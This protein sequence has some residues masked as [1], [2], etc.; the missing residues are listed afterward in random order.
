[1]SGGHGDK[2][3]PGNRP[4]SPPIRGEI[5]ELQTLLGIG[6]DHSAQAMLLVDENVQT[7]CAN[8]SAGLLFGS[9]PSALVGHRNADFAAVEWTAD[10]DRQTV[11]FRLGDLDHLER[12]TEVVTAT[13]DHVRAKMLVDVINTDGGRRYFLLQ[14]RDI[15]EDRDR[16]A[17]LAASEL[18]YRLLV[19]QPAAGGRLHVRSRSAAAA[20]GG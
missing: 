19:G 5:A 20:G 2:L 13:G 10:G 18:R 17:A 4:S 7:V 1:M 6:F 14:L 9:E 11:A 15:T 8:P 12:E 3:P 16:S